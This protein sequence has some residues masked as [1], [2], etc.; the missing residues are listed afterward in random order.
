MS[1]RDIV[2]TQKRE[3]AK[4]ISSLY[5]KRTYDSSAFS[6]QIIKVIIGPRRAGKSFFAL[7]ELFAISNNSPNNQKPSNSVNVPYAYLNFDDERL[8]KVENYDD[9]LNQLLIQY[10]GAK[11]LF[12][13]EIQNLPNWEIWVNRLQRNGYHIVLTGSNS[14]LLSSELASTLT[15]RYIPIQIFPFSYSEYLNAITISESN[16]LTE[17]EQSALFDEYIFTVGSQSDLVI[18]GMKSRPKPS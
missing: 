16:D 1:L 8:I 9:I 10:P 6:H 12:L 18:I 4:I 15:G 13:D 5:V 3:K 7:H 14:N 11:I 2:L 17:S